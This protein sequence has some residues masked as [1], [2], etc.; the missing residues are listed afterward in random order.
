MAHTVD[1]YYETSENP[2]VWILVVENLPSHVGSYGFP[3]PEAFRIRTRVRL[4]HDGELL[5]TSYSEWITVGRAR[6]LTP[7]MT[8]LLGGRQ[9]ASRVW[10][11]VENADG[12]HIDRSDF[13][14]GF[15]VNYHR[16]S[17]VGTANVRIARQHGILSLAPE[18][19]TSPLNRGRND[20]YGPAIEIGRRFTIWVGSNP[21]GETPAFDDAWVIFCGYIDDHDFSG[22]VAEI[23]GRDI[24]GKV[25]DARIEEKR[26]YG[27]PLPGLPA[28]DVLT[29]IVQDNVPG[30]PVY[31]P[32]PIDVEFG[33]YPQD[34]GLTLE[35]VRSKGLEAG[36]DVRGLWR[37]DTGEFPLWIYQPDTLSTEP[38]YVFSKDE[39]FEMRQY[40]VSRTNVKN[41]VGGSFRDEAGLKVEMDTMIDPVSIARYR[42]RAY[43]N[44]DL[45]TDSPIRTAEAFVRF[46]EGFLR[47]M[48]NP[49]INLEIRTMFF[50]P[51]GLNRVY[52]FEADGKRFAT[53]KNFACVGFRHVYQKGQGNGDS[54]FDTYILT[55]GNPAAA[56]SEYI[57]KETTEP[58]PTDEPPDLS[59]ELVTSV[60]AT[61]LDPETLNVRIEWALA[62]P[63]TGHTI[64]ILE[65]RGLGSF[66]TIASGIAITGG[67]D[68]YDHNI[69]G[70]TT[71]TVRYRVM[72][73]ETGASRTT[74]PIPLT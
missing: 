47:D 19:D 58:V 41:A 3:R 13:L 25:L 48:A 23:W 24:H 34:V 27:A 46:Q 10:L 71:D 50:W 36:A 18:L 17:P 66:D 51:A 4:Y 56:S 54:V 74:A 30:W 26:F 5:E 33:R 55:R 43:S 32:T 62:N 20:T 45:G 44:F 28:A 29:Q 16:D 11:V 21:I 53:Q 73:A 68:S 72:I 35:K 2:G 6:T 1:L 69:V 49:D 64:T 65:D 31:V 70:E 9:R 59:A 12:E 42:T 38:A 7:E 8:S 67:S 15:E 37:D 40:R 57:E 63:D 22:P 52:G 61:L 60:T 14:L 39:W